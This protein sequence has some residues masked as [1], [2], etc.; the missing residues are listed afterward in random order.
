MPDYDAP[1]ADKSAM[2]IYLYSLNNSD[3]SPVAA[4]PDGKTIFEDNCAVCHDFDYIRPKL[5]GHSRDRI[6][7]DLDRLSALNDAMPDFDGTDQE[8]AVLADYM[9]QQAGGAQ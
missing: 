1:D 6:R 8:K 3:A 7:A 9:Y 5:S 4:G 2:A